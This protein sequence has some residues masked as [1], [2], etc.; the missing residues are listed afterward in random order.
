MQGLFRSVADIAL[1]IAG[2]AAEADYRRAAELL[3]GSSLVHLIAAGNTTS[4][5]LNIGPRL[6][7]VGIRCTYSTLPEQYMHH[8]RLGDASEA[9]LAVSG[10][11]TSKYVVK[12]LELAR[13]RGM[14]SV[15]V[16]AYQFSPVS[17]L[18]D[19]LLL[20]AP[21]GDHRHSL[22]RYSRLSEMMVLEVLAGLLESA[23]PDGGDVFVDSEMF[24][25]ETKF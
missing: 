25:S 18:A 7:R 14:R 8:I 13:E 1:G 10:S 6:E 20:S 9:V 21:Q 23:L 22:I 4:L 2:T 24:L 17:R 11:G 3:R 5:C 19:H 15:A 12:A 16:T